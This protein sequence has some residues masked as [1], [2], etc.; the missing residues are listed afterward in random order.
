MLWILENCITDMRISYSHHEKEVRASSNKQLHST[1]LRLLRIRDHK[2]ILNRAFSEVG[3]IMFASE[4]IECQMREAVNFGK[5]PEIHELLRRE[6]ML[7]HIRKRETFIEILGGDWFLKIS[8]LSLSCF[9]LKFQRSE[10]NKEV[11][12][13]LIEGWQQNNSPPISAA[14]SLKPSVTKSQVP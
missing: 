13:L 1:S 11:E 4:I 14:Q 9:I 6:K 3:Y 8:K 7:R 5:F 12:P 2:K 10:D